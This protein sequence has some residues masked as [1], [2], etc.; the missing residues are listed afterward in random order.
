MFVTGITKA[1]VMSGFV[2]LRNFCPFFVFFTTSGRA[3]LRAAKFF[4]FWGCSCRCESTAFVLVLFSI[5]F[6][7]GCNPVFHERYFSSIFC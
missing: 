6:S 5:P 4:F 7:S 2:F 3:L 1:C